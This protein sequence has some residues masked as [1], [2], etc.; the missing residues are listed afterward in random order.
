ME[1]NK[2]FLTVYDDNSNYKVWV[3]IIYVQTISLAYKLKARLRK[4]QIFY[5]S[6]VHIFVYGP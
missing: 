5:Q 2:L 3:N 1:P 4:N 6:L